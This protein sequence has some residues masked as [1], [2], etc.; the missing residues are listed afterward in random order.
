M[1]ISQT[2]I[3]TLTAEVRREV[4]TGEL[5][6]TLLNRFVQS[7]TPELAVEMFMQLAWDLKS[8]VDFVDNNVS[9]RTD[10]AKLMAIAVDR[11]NDWS[12]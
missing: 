9:N 4:Q 8:F 2:T 11:K 5:E 7:S 12:T 1:K 3:D 10:A 6:S